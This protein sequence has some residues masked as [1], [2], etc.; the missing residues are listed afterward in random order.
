MV[1]SSR[2]ARGLPGREEI[3]TSTRRTRAT[4]IRAD[5]A[6]TRTHDRYPAAGQSRYDSGL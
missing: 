5:Y 6:P 1:S 4:T 3:T 2:R